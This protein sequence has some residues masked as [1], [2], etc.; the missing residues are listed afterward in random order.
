MLIETDELSASFEIVS[1]CKSFKCFRR[2]L[3]NKVFISLVVKGKNTKKQLD[4]ETSQSL[5]P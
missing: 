1:V 5:C 3:K 4:E 2:C